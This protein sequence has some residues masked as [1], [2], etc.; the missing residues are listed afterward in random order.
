MQQHLARLVR[1]KIMGSP[2]LIQ[3]GSD[4]G[5]LRWSLRI[6]FQAVLMLLE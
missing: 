4:S 3:G 6:A 2:L 1:T 5:D